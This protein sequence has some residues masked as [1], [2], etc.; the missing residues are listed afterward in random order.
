MRSYPLAD[1]AQKRLFVLYIL[2][3]L[4]TGLL[5]VLLWRAGNKYQDAVKADADARIT[6]AGSRAAQA[7]DSAAKANERAQTL[8]HDN[9]TLR[10]QIAT[11]EE[12]AQQLLLQTEKEARRRAEAEL[13]LAGIQ[14]HEPPRSLTA[15]QVSHFVEALKER[16]KGTV[17]IV[18]V[19]NNAE[20]MA[21]MKEIASL[22]KTAGWNVK[23]ESR[24][25][26]KG[27]PNGVII[28]TQSTNNPPAASLQKAFKFIGFPTHGVV[29][30]TVPADEVR[31][32]IGYK[33]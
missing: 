1:R 29:N 31:L 22:M 16:P 33:P 23:N 14:A 21:F 26:F 15:K 32:I 25:V 27:T 2:V 30:E 11:L 10:T 24:V 18:C 28:A 7:Y 9:L 12:R 5:T 8:E 6:E 13:K 3:L 19:W 20:A 17:D 4:I